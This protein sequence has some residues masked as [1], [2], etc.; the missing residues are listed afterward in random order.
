MW[1]NQLWWFF[2]TG[3]FV[4]G[5]SSFF[6]IALLVLIRGFGDL[7]KMVYAMRPNSDS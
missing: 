5:S 7:R 4:L 6:L 1:S 2:W 3:C